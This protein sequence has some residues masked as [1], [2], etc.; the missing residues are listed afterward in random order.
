MSMIALRNVTKTYRVSK[1]VAVT[2]VH[3]VS[4][5][6]DR[7][8]FVIITGRSG[9]G[10]TT[11]L[12]LAAGLARPT[13]GDVLLNDTNLWRLS[14][15]EQ[16]LLR[17]QKLGFVFQFPSLL[18]SLNVLENVVLPRT[19]GVNHTGHDPHERATQL[20][21]MVGLSDKLAA[22]PR[23][24]SAGQQQRVVIARALINEPEVILADEP[25]SNLDEQTEQEIM[26]LFRDI[27]RQTGVTIV[28]VTHT[29]QL[30]SYGTRAIQMAGGLIVHQ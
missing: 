15:R 9:S 6:V 17:N 1:E 19:F 27:H 13:S 8:E 29:S 11:L 30:V 5:N 25:T 3:G 14:D 20:L 4:L 24:L 10:K 12:N 26:N 2:A 22:Y 21:G 23:Q 7:G 18:P 28:V 16:S